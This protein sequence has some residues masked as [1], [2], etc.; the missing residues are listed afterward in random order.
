MEFVELERLVGMQNCPEEQSGLFDHSHLHHRHHH[1]WIVPS[2]S[3]V[4]FAGAASSF[5]FDQ[6]TT[7]VVAY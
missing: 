4:A 2:S 6:R 3:V 7:V 1:H 5:D